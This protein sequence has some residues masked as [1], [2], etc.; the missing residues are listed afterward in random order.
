MAQELA[1]KQVAH[2]AGWRERG[3]EGQGEEKEKEGDE[4]ETAKQNGGDEMRS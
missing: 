2:W 1:G 4:E 3:M